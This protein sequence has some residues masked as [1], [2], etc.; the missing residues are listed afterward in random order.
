MMSVENYRKTHSPHEIRMLFLEKKPGVPVRFGCGCGIRIGFGCTLA[1]SFL[2]P[3][4]LFLVRFLDNFLVG[5]V[6]LITQF[7]GSITKDA[8]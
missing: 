7:F 5:G 1:H 4:S 6:A 8:F 2:S 3:S